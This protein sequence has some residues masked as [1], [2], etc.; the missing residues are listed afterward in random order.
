MNAVED[1]GESVPALLSGSFWNTMGL[2]MFIV[3]ICA[4]AS[5]IINIW[6]S[7]KYSQYLSRSTPGTDLS[8]RKE[9]NDLQVS[10]W[11]FMG[12]PIV[13]VGLAVSFMI[14][15]NEL[16]DGSAL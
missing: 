11:F 4:L 16:E 15:E 3:F 6:Y 7:V 1:I 10:S 13:N 8:L 2:W 5:F 12:L 14:K 9:V